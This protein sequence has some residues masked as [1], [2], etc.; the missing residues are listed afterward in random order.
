MNSTLI[1]MSFLII[2][3]KSHIILFIIRT[4]QCFSISILSSFFILLTKNFAMK[5]M[6]LDI[7]P[8]SATF[9]CEAGLVVKESPSE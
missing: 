8:I 6:S 9:N 1:S 2:F 5:G 3:I 7:A 4:F